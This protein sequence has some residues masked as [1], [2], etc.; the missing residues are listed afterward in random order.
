MAL[1][2]HLRELRARILKVAVILT[3]GLVVSLFFFDQIFELVLRPYTDAQAGAARGRRTPR[4]PS[5]VPAGR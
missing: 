2:D 3:V 1:S 5:P 4:P